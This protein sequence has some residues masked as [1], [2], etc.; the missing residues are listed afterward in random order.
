MQI[1]K[2]RRKVDKY[3]VDSRICNLNLQLHINIHSVR[4]LLTI[5]H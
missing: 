3:F 1:V 5:T 2:D 4:M